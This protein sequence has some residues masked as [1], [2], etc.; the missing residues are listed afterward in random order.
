MWELH[1]TYSSIVL[2]RL[3]SD[4]SPSLQFFQNFTEAAWASDSDVCKEKLVVLLCN[5]LISVGGYDQI[6]SCKPFRQLPEHSHLQILTDITALAKSHNNP[7]TDLMQA[8]RKWVHLFQREH[9]CLQETLIWLS[10]F[11]YLKC[12]C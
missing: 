7:V 2:L 3:K 12:N 4:K 6:Q 9:I 10:V 5:V 1:P 11:L 8:E